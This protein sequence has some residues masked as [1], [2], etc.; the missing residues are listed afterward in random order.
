VTHGAN[1]LLADTPIDFTAQ[2][3][4]L[5]DAPNRGAGI[6]AAGRELVQAKF[7]WESV[8]EIFEGF[9]RQA[10]ELGKNRK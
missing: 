9:C 4:S 5:F 1:I 10:C 8:N 6:G 3:A 2:I 7:S